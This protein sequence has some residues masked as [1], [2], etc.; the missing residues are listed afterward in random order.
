MLRPVSNILIVNYNIAG[1]RKK[2]SGNTV[3]Q[4]R[5]PGPVRPYNRNKI[6]LFNLQ[7]DIIQCEN[8]IHTPLVE[9]FN[10]AV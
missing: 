3:E 6:A 1:I 5:F 7:V 9:V 8:L 2:A 10:N 4:G